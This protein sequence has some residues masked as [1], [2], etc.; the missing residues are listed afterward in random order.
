MLHSMQAPF[1]GQ[2]VPLHYSKQPIPGPSSEEHFS[3]IKNLSVII[4]LLN[5]TILNSGSCGPVQ[6]NPSPYR[7]TQTRVKHHQFSN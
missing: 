4:R 3:V 7:P 5:P 6:L 1:T 2:A